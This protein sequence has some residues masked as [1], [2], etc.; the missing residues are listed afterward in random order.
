MKEHKVTSSKELF[1]LL[2]EFKRKKS[3]AFRGQRD[4]TWK[5]LSKAGRSEFVA[6][7]R[8]GFT[9][10]RAFEAWKRYAVHFLNRTPIDE[11][12]WLTLAQHHGLAT[13]LLDWTKNPLNAAFF[14]I[15][16]NEGINAAI[17]AFEIFD[18]DKASETDPFSLQGLRVYFPKGLSA[19]IVS[20]RGIFTASHSPTTPI[21]DEL[22]DR[23]YK[24]TLD[25]STTK[26]LRQTL[27]FFGINKLSIY[28]DLDHL[29]EY[30]ND[31][32]VDYGL[33]ASM[34]GEMPFG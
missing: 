8:L 11:W 17:Y 31:Y 25:G 34:G 28:Q 5:L 13:R 27:E 16:R 15:D 32:V 22:G 6:G 18:T 9:E 30:L 24:V 12:D 19:R 21:E 33:N 26:D 3:W 10:E 20:Q 29:S 4:A 23:L 7:Y 2:H 1:D 14:A